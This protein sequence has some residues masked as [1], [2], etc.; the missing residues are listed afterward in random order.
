[1]T[2]FAQM[3]AAVI[4]KT[5]RPEL[6]ELTNSAIRIATTRA[7]QVDFFR[8]DQA[9][10]ALTYTVTNDLFVNIANIFATVARLRTVDFLQ[11]VEAASPYK[12]V[13]NLEYRDYRD[14]WNADNELREHVFT[15]IGGTL[16][17][18][19]L[20]PTGRFNLLYY[21]N[22]NVA[23]VGYS[24]W[25]A[26][27]HIDELAMWAAGVIWARTGN[28]EQAHLT[29]RDHVT[30]FKEMLVESYLIAKV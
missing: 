6:V 5:R 27:D 20:N 4:D 15:L 8:R 24:S 19:V 17:A 23:E 11:G 25:I 21:Q 30:P 28:M 18:R 12:P 16:R 13:E 7:H 29:M 3:Q 1:M 10:A 9:E 14:F 2:T 26:D 22:P